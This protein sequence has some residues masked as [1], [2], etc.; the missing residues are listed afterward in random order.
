MPQGRTGVLMGDILSKPGKVSKKMA[1]LGELLSP[2][3]I[4]KLLTPSRQLSI[5]EAE[6]EHL[7]LKSRTFSP[8]KFVSV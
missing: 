1:N 7:A 8:L 3:L 2:A 4:S 5:R 6:F